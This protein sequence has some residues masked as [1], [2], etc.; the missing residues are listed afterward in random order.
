MILLNKR[1]IVTSLLHQLNAENLIGGIIK[2]ENQI[3]NNNSTPLIDD[4]EISDIFKD[5]DNKEGNGVTDKLI[6]EVLQ[7][8]V[9]V[10]L[11]ARQIRDIITGQ[12]QASH[13]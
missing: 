12:A 2:K 4:L 13:K 3:K 11:A 9:Q 6:N 1:M 5:K 8:L 7:L 10:G